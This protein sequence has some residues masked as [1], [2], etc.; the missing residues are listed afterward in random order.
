MFLSLKNLFQL[1]LSSDYQPQVSV[2]V[3][4]KIHQRIVYTH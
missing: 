3:Y 1:Y 4:N 2:A